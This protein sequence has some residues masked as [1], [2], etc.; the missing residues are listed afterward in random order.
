MASSSDCVGSMS[1][2]LRTEMQAAL[3]VR[4]GLGKWIVALAV[5]LVLGIAGI[6]TMVWLAIT[7][8]PVA[9][10]IGAIVAMLPVPLYLLLAIWL[11]RF[12]MEPLYLM[13]LAFGWGATAAV[14]ISL[15]F[16]G[17]NSVIVESL[18]GSEVA[19]LMTPILS[20]P[21]VEEFAKAIILFAIYYWKY[22]EFDG[23]VDGVVYASLVGLGF[24]MTE[25]ILYYGAALT[26]GVGALAI[27]FIARGVI[28]PF[29]HSLFTS[30]TG[31]GLGIRRHARRP[32]AS[33][34]PL[35]GFALAVAAHMMWNG[36]LFVVGD[37]PW[38]W[39][40]TV[41][42]GVMVPTFIGLLVVVYLSLCREGD[43]VRKYLR[44]E[45]EDGIIHTSDY[46]QLCRIGGRLRAS[47]Q[48][49]GRWGPGG[50]WR[51]WRF[52]Q[53]ASE[54]AFCRH[55]HEKDE[56]CRDPAREQSYRNELL[57]IYQSFSDE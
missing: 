22:D 13:G 19:M 7:I 5:L 48:A 43:I 23:I 9:L 32:L 40:I 53:V 51:R 21:I 39:F 38:L 20:A 50:L 35:G 3:S 31:I 55:R 33:W 17:L 47:L 46:V 4:T 34:A 29:S 56:S 27:T 14:F 11:D 28:S 15:L 12:E 52:H 25:N 1:E 54:L 30:M 10:L 24:A 45:V 6:A 57:R 16:N 2:P 36:S 41:Y 44:P 49:F 37:P 18:F 42:P 26:W 8:N